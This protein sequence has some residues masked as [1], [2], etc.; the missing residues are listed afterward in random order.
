MKK[1]IIE[2]TDEQYE[3]IKKEQIKSSKTNFIEE[4]FNGFQFL[5]SIVEGGIAC[6]EFEANNKIDLGEVT[7]K[8]E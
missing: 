8:I 6:F 7:Y 3:Q 5:L 4:T 2:L 1:L